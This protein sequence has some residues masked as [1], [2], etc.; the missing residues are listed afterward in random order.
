MRRFAWRPDSLVTRL[1]AGASVIWNTWERRAAAELVG[2][3]EAFLAG[4]YAERAER[5]GREVPTWAWL[6]LL[7]HGTED[8]V[9]AE[10]W[11]RGPKHLDQA[12]RW[13]EARSY[14]AAE[15]LSLSESHGPLAEIQR[16]V[17]VPVE[18]ELASR[19]RVVRDPRDLVG[20][21]KRALDCHR[22]AARRPGGVGESRRRHI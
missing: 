14:L 8:E 19:P 17:L 1:E 21:A 9:R 5:Q 7:A 16:R 12:Q 3:C 20:K 18:Q 22:R 15:V 11:L 2:D 13:R 4:S 10:C 6:N